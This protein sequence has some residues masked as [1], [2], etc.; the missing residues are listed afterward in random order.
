M[1]KAGDVGEAEDE[2]EGEVMAVAVRRLESGGWR[3]GCVSD[4]RR[5]PLFECGV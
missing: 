2:D 5:G 4:Q 1:R 3:I